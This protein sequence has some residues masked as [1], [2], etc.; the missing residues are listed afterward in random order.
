MSTLM[1]IRRRLLATVA[2]L[3]LVMLGVGLA[4]LSGIRAVNAELRSVNEDNMPAVLA[5]GN[6][7][8]ALARARLV[9]NRI[10]FDPDAPDHSQNLAWA[11]GFMR[12]ADQLWREYSALPQS[13]AEAA[14]AQ[15]LGQSRAAYLASYQRLV[16]S[17]QA[18]RIAEAQELVR[19]ALQPQFVRLTEQAE[20][21]NDFQRQALRR[22]YA[23]SQE[24][25]LVQRNV[26]VGALLLALLLLALSAAALLRAIL[27]PLEAA[28]GHCGAIARGEL[29]HPIVAARQDEMGLLLGGLRGMQEQLAGTVRGVRGG[30]GAI[31]LASAE[32]AAGNLDL[33]RRTER[34]AADLEETAAALAA[35]T[36]AV[37]E[38]AGHVA[39]ASALAA[40]AAGVAGRGGAL[41]AQVVD[42]IHDISGAAERI[43]AITGVIDGIA[44]QTNLLAL[45]AAVE[46]ARAG[47]HGRG[48]AVVAS[49]V[50]KLAQHSAAAAGDIK[51]LVGDTL[52]RLR[53]GDTLAGEAGHTMAGL[54]GSVQQVALLMEQLSAAS[55]EQET[56]IGQINSAV[57]DID[58]AT[59]QNAALVEQAAAAAQALQEQADQ[60]N[61]M[62][63]AFVLERAEGPAGRRLPKMYALSQ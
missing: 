29:C 9:M 40:D 19:S 24:A 63:G 8:L 46:A 60:L 10:M 36:H 47:E 31:A 33:S 7:Q 15:E 27:G 11:D 53:A 2:A 50:R 18:H 16:A 14:L 51:R 35:M 17:V 56:G 12:Q 57:A 41:V 32:I 5:I 20:R 34:Q 38:G 55:R 26:T 30:A 52:G 1:T 61:A 39:K 54:V 42:T 37:Q 44:F 25:Y 58:A 48:F 4:G 22:D 3:G 6:F 49:E 59:Q 43:G 28:L 23:A 62:V 45:N 21:L 13:G